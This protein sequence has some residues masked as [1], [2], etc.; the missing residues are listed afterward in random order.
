MSEEE[1]SSTRPPRNASERERD[2]KIEAE[3]Y[4]KG[5]S[6]Q[7][8]AVKLNLSPATVS[9]DLKSLH[10]Q[11]REART[12]DMTTAKNAEL[13]RLDVLEASYWTAW[14]NS[15]K[16]A[17]AQTEAISGPGSTVSLNSKR[18]QFGDPR[19]L[20]GVM[21]CIQK[22]CEILGLN[23]PKQMDLRNN[24]KPMWAQFINATINLPPGAKSLEV[25]QQIQ[26]AISVDPIDVESESAE[27][28][29]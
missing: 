4:L 2:L 7:E 20:N 17:H 27:S 25:G 1:T 15:L 8:I 18:Q 16:T 9:R 21:A 29:P 10:E 12:I 28:T 26:D 23:A 19:F 6:Q 11:W 5:K 24:G 14:E 22:R 3:M 13:A